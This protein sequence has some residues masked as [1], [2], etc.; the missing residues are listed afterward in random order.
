M[1]KALPK[2]CRSS[3]NMAFKLKIVA[4]AE[5]VEN[6]SEITRKYGLSKS[7]VCHWWKDQAKLFNS[8]LRMSAKRTTMGHFTPKFPELDQQIL[9]WFTEQ[10]EQGE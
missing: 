7:M 9:E 8:E 5:A 4:K 3:Y 2:A 10:R 1:P 6:N